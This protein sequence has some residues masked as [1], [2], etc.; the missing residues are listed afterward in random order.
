MK[1]PVFVKKA[2]FFVFYTQNHH[3]YYYPPNNYFINK[4]FRIKKLTIFAPR[5]KKTGLKK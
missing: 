5:F 4:C 2:G 3:P 1:N